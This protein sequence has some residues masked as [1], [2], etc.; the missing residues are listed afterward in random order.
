MLVEA[1]AG[2]VRANV[3]VAAAMGGGKTTLCQALLAQVPKDERIDTI[4]DTPELAPAR[5]RHPPQRLR[6]AHTRR[7]QRRRGPARP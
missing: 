1:I 4:E 5:V 6:A 3:V 7:Q 2:N